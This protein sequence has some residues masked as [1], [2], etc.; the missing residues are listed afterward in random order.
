MKTFLVHWEKILFNT[1][2]LKIMEEDITYK[3]KDLLQ[4]YEQWLKG[5]RFMTE[6]KIATYMEFVK[7][8]VRDS[9]DFLF[10]EN[11]IDSLASIARYD[12]LHHTR[13]V[14]LTSKMLFNVHYDKTISHLPKSDNSYFDRRAALQKLD[15]FILS[16][17]FQ[18]KIK[19][20]NPASET[21]I[22]DLRMWRI[23]QE[24][25]KK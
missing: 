14:Q 15:T 9:I 22:S 17:S 16:K 21:L 24:T 18:E 5:F 19:D 2:T 12:Q 3:T 11:L 23:I 13:Y 7:L 20:M 25:M 4:D 1:Q 10:A 6:E 8:F